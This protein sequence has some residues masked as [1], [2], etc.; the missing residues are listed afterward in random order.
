VAVVTRLAIACGVASALAAGCA[1]D[2]DPASPAPELDVSAFRC[3][4]QPV[5]AARCAFAGCHA[6]AVRPFHLYAVGRMRYAIGWDRL[7]EPLTE[8]ELAA[9]YEAARNFAVGAEPLVLAKP[10]DTRAGGY[11]H[12]GADL[13]GDDDVFLSVD[14]PGYRAIA[15]WI[16]GATAPATCTETEEVGP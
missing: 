9:N 6:S 5:L 10:L 16:D 2:G 12:R 3:A 15:E 13:Y 1:A 11:F 7:E 4:V 14:D 8:T